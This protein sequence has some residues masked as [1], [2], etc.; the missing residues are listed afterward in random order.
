[1]NTFYSRLAVAALLLLSAP[2]ARPQASPSLEEGFRSAPAADKPWAYWWWLKGN[3][4]PESIT[5]DLEAMARAGFG[6]FLMFD[7]R[8]YHEDH[9]P[10][11]PSRM[12]FM[13]PEWRILLKHSLKEAGRLGLQASV[14][15]SSCAGAL[16]GP[17]QVGDDAPKK[18]VWTAAETR[19]AQL[20]T[21]DLRVPQDKRFWDVAVLAVRHEAPGGAAPAAAATPALD[22]S[23]RWQD[24]AALAAPL[25]A[26]LEVADLSSR[27]DARGRL[28]WRAPAGH[29]TVL[30]FGC[31]TMENH[32]YDVD[33]LDRKAVTGHFER[34]GRVLLQDAG[35]LAGRTLTHF[36]SVSWEGAAPTWTLAI[37]KEFRRRR[38]YDLRPWL[39]ALAGFAVKDRALSERFLRDYYKTLGDCFMDNFYGTL[40]ELSGRAGL[41][42]HSE[43][44]GPWDRKLA[45]FEQADQL[46][47]LGR[48]DMPQGEFWWPRRSLNRPVAMAAH[49]YGRP[50]AAAEAFTHMAQHWSAYPA[51][52]KPRAD[53][54]F[55]DGINHLVWHTFTA[56]PPELG[57]PGSEYFAGTH[58]NP[59]VTW[60]PQ[61]GPFLDYLGRSQFLLRQGRFV[62][63]VCVYVGD[64]NY[65]H[66][67]RGTNWGDKPSLRLPRGYSYDLVNTEVLVERLAVRG[68]DLALPDGMR[69]RMLVVDL[70]DTA[71]P[72][73]ALRKILKL[74]RAGAT[75]VLG[76]RQPQRAPGLADYPRCE[77]AVRRLAAQLW[78]AALPASA[79][80]AAAAESGA[81]VGR[82]RLIAGRPVAD[83]LRQK[84]ILPDFEGPWDYTHRR[85]GDTEVYF[86]SGQGSA[87]CAFRV[88]GKEPELWDP[89]TGAIREAMAW[90]ATRDGRTLVPIALPTNGSVFVVFRQPARERHLFSGPPPDTEILGREAGGVRARV[91]QKDPLVL[92]GPW[93][94]RFEQSRGAPEM[95]VFQ[96]LVPWNTH[97]DTGIRHFSGQAAYQKSFDLGAAQAAQPV[98]LQLGEVRHIAQVRLN[99]RDLGVVWTDPWSVD[100]T[101]AV[102]PGRNDLEIVVV[103]TWV[104]RLIGDA[105]LPKDQRITQSNVS[106]QPGDRAF[107]VYQGFAANDPLMPSGLL[108][109]VRLEFGRLE[110]LGY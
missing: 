30:R 34:M 48:N 84:G 7:A 27:V 31:V 75:I 17:W 97:T 98:R 59:N 36:Y 66:W 103:N 45:A 51:T 67:D 24:V 89:V 63:D 104:N 16:K 9:V 49:I 88:S 57:K 100:L 35:P 47:F 70:E 73:E 22:L 60:W 26:V 53:A 55:C 90:R 41:K 19:G 65:L 15:L 23:S 96:D 58:L 82:G 56:S 69:Y 91:W 20:L 79:S 80:A 61:A 44:G 46:A 14:N 4:T 92:R 108:G 13:S 94:V 110:T 102:K 43:S 54:A 74:A 81:P 52:L 40:R 21:C 39:P 50:L 42:W 25:P 62:A 18:L 76:Q 33:I 72:P 32:E 71:V 107:K 95:V 6:G 1:M 29:W 5:R 105:A 101:G 99:G 64:R 28:A 10:P 38:G 8:G 85:D 78:G 2:L 77:E 12:E 86:I 3:V 68:D 11:P 106:L 87:E 37:E 83:A 109:P 93:T